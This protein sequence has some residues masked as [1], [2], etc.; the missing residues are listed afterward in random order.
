MKPDPT[1]VHPRNASPGG[2]ILVVDDLAVFRYMQ[3]CRIRH[4][5]EFS[6]YSGLRA[7][8]L[9]QIKPR[10]VV[11]ALFAEGFDSVA[12]LHRLEKQGFGGRVICLAPPLPDRRIVLAE[13]RR[14][15]KSLRLDL[16]QL[17]D[18]KSRMR[19]H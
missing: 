10:C 2:T 6:R 16:L 7:P 1:A 8:L 5:I 4:R 3:G 15:A 12:A 19:D 11:F 9:A 17:P 14:E 18:Q 13:L